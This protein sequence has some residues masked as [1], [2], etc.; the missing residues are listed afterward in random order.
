MCVCVSLLNAAA[1]PTL[2]EFKFTWREI[3]NRSKAGRARNNNWPNKSTSGRPNNNASAADI[4]CRHNISRAATV[5]S[6]YALRFAPASTVGCQ[7]ATTGLRVFQPASQRLLFQRST[8][9]AQR[10]IKRV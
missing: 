8:N 7:M 5:G 4:T 2:A 10:T 3:D 6:T 9:L 1:F